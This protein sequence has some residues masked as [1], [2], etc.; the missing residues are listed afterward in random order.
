MSNLQTAP[1]KQKPITH[2]NERMSYAL[3]FF[4]ALI[5]R[6]VSFTKTDNE[7]TPLF[8]EKHYAPQSYDMVKSFINPLLGGI[9]SNPGYGLVVHPP[10]AKQLQSIGEMI[11]G[12]TPL[13]WRV[14]A[15]FFGAATI[16]V[17]RAIARELTGSAALA[18][19]AGILALFDGVLLV[20][21]RS[22]MLDIFQTFFIVAATYTFIKD[23]NS[24]TA[25]LPT[26]PRTEFGPRLGYRWWL[27]TTGVLLGCAVSVKWS[28]LYY[29]AFLGI[30]SV[31]LDWH[32]RRQANVRYAFFG[33]LFLDSFKAF[34][35]LVIIP[36]GVY[37]WSWR[38]WFASETAV[39]RHAK[40]SGSIDQAS[41][42]QFFPNTL[43]NWLHYHSSVLKFHASLTTSS[44]H[45]HPFDSKPWEW[46]IGGKPILYYSSN[47]ECFGTNCAEKIYLFGTPTIWWLTVPVIVL[48][49]GI[50][51]YRRSWKYAI[52]VIVFMA[53]FIPW[54]I[55]YD[56]Q[57]YFFYATPLVPMT[58]ICLTLL[59][60]DLARKYPRIGLWTLTTIV[61]T[62]T[63]QFFFFSPI[64]YGYALPESWFPALLWFPYWGS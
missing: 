9:E 39:F 48:A 16:I 20:T 56:R 30:A 28:G 5:T 33:T 52:P 1:A 37:V 4:A 13:G 45:D 60:G 62:A 21:S 11:F 54:L 31:V 22:G 50:W 19:T 51:L 44:G 3:L 49:L 8:D 53:G 64:L 32:R 36:I 58:I 14:V 43:A 55:G 57:M 15:A 47:H 29:M 40:E 18:N 59:L 17:I 23:W 12:Y 6:F 34:F 10:L 26:A 7:Q 42:L 41:L 38:A 63:A 27:L 2:T 24:T 35:Y 25:L 46:L 61:G